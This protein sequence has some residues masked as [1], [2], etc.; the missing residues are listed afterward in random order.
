MDFSD[1]LRQTR[2]F[3]GLTLEELGRRIGYSIG[4]IND[5]ENKRKIATEKFKATVRR[6]FPRND[7]FDR[8]LIEAKGSV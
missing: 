7:A 5:I 4:H 2:Y 1:Y 6:E 8:F 3:Y